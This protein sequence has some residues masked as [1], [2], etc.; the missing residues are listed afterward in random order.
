MK[1]KN[2]IIGLL[3]LAFLG[4]G[5]IYAGHYPKGVCSQLS[6]YIAVGLLSWSRLIIEPIGGLILFAFFLGVYI[7]TVIHGLFI[8]KKENSNSG[9]KIY[10]LILFPIACFSIFTVTF[11][12][13]SLLLGIEINKISSTSMLPIL[14]PNDYILSN[15]WAYQEKMPSEGDIVIFKIDNKA[16]MVKRVH[17]TPEHLHNNNLN[18][19]Y[20]LGDNPHNSMDS[21][22]LGLI[23]KNK[24]Q[25]Q[26]SYIIYPSNIMPFLWKRIGERL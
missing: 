15:T 22:Y 17:K 14:H 7:I 6:L 26:V 20:L 16:T 25:G 3:N 9:K 11:I 19:L 8:P 23:E 1:S 24:I 4:W 5:Y 21:R 10:A 2:L 12:Q 18:M 13:K